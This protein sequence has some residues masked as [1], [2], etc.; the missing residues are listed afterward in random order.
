MAGIKH[1]FVSGKSDGADPTMLQPSNWDD[2][3]EGG[4]ELALIDAKGDLIVG[5]AADTVVRLP[6]GADGLVVVSDSG[7]TYGLAWGAVPGLAEL[8][9]RVYALETGASPTRPWPL[10]VTTGTYTVPGSIDHTGATDVTA[11]LNAFIAT[12]P[13][14][15]IIDFAEEDAIYKISAYLTIQQRSNLILEG[16]G[17]TTLNNVANANVGGSQL[18]SFFFNYWPASNGAHHITIRNFIATAASPAPGT[19]QAGEFASFAHFMAGE[20]LEVTGIVGSGFFGDFVTINEDS[21]YVWVHDNT[22][23]NVGRNNVSV[24]CGN[25]ILVEDNAFGT[26]GYTTF[27]IEPEAGSVANCTNITFRRNTCGTWTNSFVSAD[28]VASGKIVSGVVIADNTV[29]GDSLLTV[30]GIYGSARLSNLSFTG[31]ITNT[32]AAG[33]VLRFQNV[34]GV[35]VS[36]NTQALSGGSLTETINCTGVSVS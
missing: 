1:K 16:N 29:T 36:D 6:V 8:A 27:D 25:Q 32:S 35:L 5:S 7:A 17:W 11:A 15:S 28:G 14:G 18:K 33:P 34:D 26:A 3:H 10:P 12:V 24:V 20:F 31:N 2:T 21:H 19:F 30:M 9:A 13:D 23:A 4:V 22:I